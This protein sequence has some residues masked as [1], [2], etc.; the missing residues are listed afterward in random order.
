MGQVRE[1][2]GKGGDRSIGNR[3]GREE[4]AGGGRKRLPWRQRIRGKAD[5]P[6]CLPPADAEKGGHLGVEDVS[7]REAQRGKG[8]GPG[9]RREPSPREAAGVQ[10]DATALT[11][12]HDGE[13]ERI[14]RRPLREAS[15]EARKTLLAGDPERIEG[16]EAGF[17]AVPRAQGRDPL[18]SHSQDAGDEVHL[19]RE[20]SIEPEVLPQNR[21]QLRYRPARYP[22][23]HPGDDGP[24]VPQRRREP[25]TAPGD[26]RVRSRHPE[27]ADQ[28]PASEDGGKEAD[29]IE[30]PAARPRVVPQIHIPCPEGPP[31]PAHDA[32]EVPRSVAGHLGQEGLRAPPAAQHLPAPKAVEPAGEP[33]EPGNGARAGGPAPEIL[34][35]A[36]DLGQPLADRSHAADTKPHAR[37]PG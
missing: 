3:L 13:G 22:D 15:E 35:P 12:G 5:L 9:D 30:T 26:G 31:S 36:Q 6:V 32:Q 28:R 19:L 2:I 8:Q 10:D 17:R 33:A 14:L 11:V 4:P 7:H 37:P 16:R 29:V 21:Q 20:G 23:P 18:L 24:L 25:D 34:H 1:D 27:K